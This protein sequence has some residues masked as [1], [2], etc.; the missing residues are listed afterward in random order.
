[1]PFLSKNP[2]GYIRAKNEE[3]LYYF[4]E[5]QYLPKEFGNNWK[6]QFEFAPSCIID[7]FVKASIPILIEVKNW[8]VRIKDM[9]QI[10]KYLAHATH[11]FKAHGF[12]FVLVAGGIENERRSL[13]EALNVE[14]ILTKDVLKRENG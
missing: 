8:F 6:K 13:L 14:I 12:R 2:S 11:R 9:Q 4:L 3:E 7:Y 5:N 1:M 10:M